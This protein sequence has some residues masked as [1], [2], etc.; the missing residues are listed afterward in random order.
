M[1]YEANLATHGLAKFALWLDDELRWWEELPLP[2]E[3]IIVNDM[4]SL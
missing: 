3:S 1:F 2:I 4:L